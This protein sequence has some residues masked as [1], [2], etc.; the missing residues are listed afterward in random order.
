MFDNLNH[1]K[2]DSL[3][4]LVSAIFPRLAVELASNVG[5]GIK[6]TLQMLETFKL[7]GCITGITCGGGLRV[8]KMF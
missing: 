8:R 7:P 4:H 5:K 3:E 2:N 1:C 6:I